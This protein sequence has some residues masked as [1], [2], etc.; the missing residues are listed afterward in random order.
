MIREMIFMDVSRALLNC[1]DPVSASL[2]M[3]ILS[4]MISGEARRRQQ[5]GLKSLATT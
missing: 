5:K 3:S 1:G 2:R 4:F